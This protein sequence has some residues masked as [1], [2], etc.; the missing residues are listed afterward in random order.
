MTYDW[1]SNLSNGYS[2]K[3]LQL[4]D[5]LSTANIWEYKIHSITYTSSTWNVTTTKVSGPTSSNLFSNRLYSIGYRTTEPPNTSYIYGW[6]AS[7]PMS[8]LNFPVSIGSFLPSVISTSGYD[9]SITSATLQFVGAV[10]Q[11][12]PVYGINLF[13][14]SELMASA[15]SSG[16]NTTN[17]K[18]RLRPTGLVMDGDSVITLTG[19]TYSTWGGITFSS[20][21]SSRIQLFVTYQKFPNAV[22]GFDPID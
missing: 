16:V 22:T 21:T 19:T 6:S 20:A 17:Q 8:G 3:I 18:Y 13:A 9:L 4:S 5:T 7:I 11:N 14:N 15:T 12:C 2:N 10:P 1:W